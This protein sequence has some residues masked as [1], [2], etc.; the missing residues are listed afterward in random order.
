M[1]KGS[2]KRKRRFEACAKFPTCRE[3]TPPR[4]GGDGGGG[5]GGGGVVV[6]VRY[7]LSFQ[8]K[9]DSETKEFKPSKLISL[10]Y[11]PLRVLLPFII[12]LDANFCMAED[13]LQRRIRLL[14]VTA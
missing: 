5:G 11:L 12:P 9:V 10:S 2:S 1:L 13:A 3:A 7:L 6:V 4:G 8:P 14:D